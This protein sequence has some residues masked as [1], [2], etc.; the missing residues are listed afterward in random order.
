MLIL[1]YLEIREQLFLKKK[2]NLDLTND[3]IL[4]PRLRCLKVGVKYI[5]LN[6]YS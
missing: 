4:Y 1:I 5:I 2:A 6:S 3:A